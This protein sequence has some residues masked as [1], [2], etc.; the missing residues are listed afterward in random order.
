[1][2]YSEYQSKAPWTFIGILM[3]FNLKYRKLLHAH[4]TPKQMLKY[5]FKPLFYEALIPF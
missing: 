3:L 5:N 1:M 2:N 4:V